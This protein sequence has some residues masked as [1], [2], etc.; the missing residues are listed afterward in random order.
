[1]LS[2]YPR[3]CGSTQRRESYNRRAIA[4]QAEAINCPASAP[5]IHTH[6]V[7]LIA[8]R[9]TATDAVRSVEVRV[10]RSGDG[11]LALKYVVAGDLGRLRVPPPAR[12]AVAERLWQ[13]TCCEIFVR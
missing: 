7:R 12:S 9:D 11:T 4:T 10:V 3:R 13:H 8:H 2:E 1:M 5:P 6:N